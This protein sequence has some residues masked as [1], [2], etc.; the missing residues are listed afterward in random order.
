MNTQSTITSRPRRLRY[1]S[2]A[3]APLL[4]LSTA[5]LAVPAGA[6]SLNV[7]FA[8]TSVD[9]GT[10]TVGTTATAQAVVTN[11]TSA[12]LYFKA[13]AAHGGSAGDFSLSSAG[14]AGALAPA[15]SCT[16]GVSFTAGAPGDRVSSLDVTLGVKGPGGSFI[17]EATVKGLLSGHGVAPDFTL[18]NANAGSVVLGSLGT[19]SIVVTNTSAVSLQVH[20]WNVTDT[21]HFF[22]VASSTCSAPLASSGTCVFVVLF[23]PKSLGAVSGTVTISLSVIGA[24]HPEFV[25]HAATVS[26]TGTKSGGS[27]GPISLSAFNAGEL[28]VGTSLSGQVSMTNVSKGTVTVLSSVLSGSNAADFKV[29]TNNCPANL[30]SGSSCQF[31]VTFAPSQPRVRTANLAITVKVTNGANHH[32]VKVSTPLSG[33]GIRPTA[34]LSAPNFGA[35]TIGSSSSAQVTVTNTSVSPLNFRTATLSGPHMP[36]W[37]VSSS[38]CSGA[39]AP[40]AS[41]EIGLTFA[42]HTQGDLSIVL[43]VVLGIHQGTHHVIVPSQVTVKGSGAEPSFSVVVPSFTAT[44]KGASS[45]AVAVITNTSDVTLSYKSAALAGG[46]VNDFTVKGTTCVGQLAPAASCNVSIS[47]HPLQSTGGA[48]S[49][50]LRIV[51]NISSITPTASVSSLST[52]NATEL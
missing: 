2:A 9:F 20:S 41:C 49:T 12:P 43:S 44:A 40:S 30:A 22:S 14:C 1:M 7:T 11:T 46:N 5:V 24:A 3:I 52:L 8:V 51:L 32:E 36:S 26:G 19:A 13:A 33:T 47:F 50:T 31:N 34:K 42:P 39:L 17:G 28:T 18:S 48:R 6:S 4:L 29:G 15:S 38:T 16:I 25:T 27:T 23:A 10:E 45:S 37:S 35:V 21:H